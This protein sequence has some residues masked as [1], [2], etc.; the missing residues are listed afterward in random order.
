[1]MTSA[2]VV[3]GQP[4]SPQT[5]LQDHTHPD[6]TVPTYDMSFGLKTFTVL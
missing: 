5:V 4:M 6:D 3:E 2:Q 1:M